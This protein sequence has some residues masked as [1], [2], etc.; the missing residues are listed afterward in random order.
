MCMFT[1]LPALSYSIGCLA[2]VNLFK[3]YFTCYIGSYLSFES[4]AVGDVG[5]DV[6]DHLRVFL[7]NHLSGDM[8][9]LVGDCAE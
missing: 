1:Y 6:A 3:D 8:S 2:L 5:D 7:D 9:D 4:S